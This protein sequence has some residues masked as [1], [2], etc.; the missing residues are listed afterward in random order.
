MSEYA[1]LLPSLAHLYLVIILFA[2]LAVR[3]FRAVKQKAVDARQAVLDNRAW[4]KEIIKVNNNIT[5]QFETPV[6]FHF[7]CLIAF[8]LNMN[9]VVPVG[10]ATAFV[11][12]RYIH[13]YVHVT[14]NYITYRFISFMASLLSL[15][16]LMVLVTLRLFS[17]L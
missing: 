5:N 11:V 3:R 16:T 17:I 4:P 7:V 9:G 13:A 2:V 1:I 8:L 14:S 6:V 12:F 15:L 10:I